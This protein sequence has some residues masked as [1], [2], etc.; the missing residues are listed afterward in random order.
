MSPAAGASAGNTLRALPT[1]VR[2]GF[3]EA[4]AYRAEFLVWILSTNMPLIMLALWHAVAREHPIGGFGTQEI[5]AYFMVTLVVR[6]LT[7]AWV[8]WE[9]NFDVRQGMMGFRLLRPVHPVVHYAAVNVGYFPLRALITAPIMLIALYFAGLDQV[10]HDPRL[11]AIGVVSIFFAWA[12]NF[13]S[14]AAIGC[15]AFYID[16]SLSIFQ[17]WF[18]AYMLLS[19]YLV[20]LSLFPPWLEQI[21]AWLPFRFMLA[22]PV[23]T[24]LGKHELAEVLRQFGVQLGYVAVLLLIIHFVWRAGVRRYAAFGG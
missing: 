20:P 8:G 18:A 14:M 16:S 6:L 23:E 19:G 1:M 4:I 10:T 24:L 22:F 12:I 5:T 17:L 9:M 2:I 3:H 11:I 7:G 15:L 21:T 13:L